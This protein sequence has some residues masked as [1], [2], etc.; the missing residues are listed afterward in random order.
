MDR[1]AERRKRAPG[2]G[3]SGVPEKPQY[4]RMGPI[5]S[6]GDDDDARSRR[7]PRRARSLR[8]DA[9]EQRR[10]AGSQKFEGF[11]IE[12]HADDVLEPGFDQGVLLTERSLAG[13]L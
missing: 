3:Q 11:V 5:A 2:V 8:V 7:H 4:F 13:R 6:V 9:D 1:L 12:R 10:Q